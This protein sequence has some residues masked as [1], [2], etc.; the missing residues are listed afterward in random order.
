MQYLED[1]TSKF[2]RENIVYVFSN[3]DCCEEHQRERPSLYDYN[4]GYMPDYPNPNID[5]KLDALSKI[6]KNNCNC[7]CR[8]VSRYICRIDNDEIIL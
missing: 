1:D 5:W 6:G 4:S 3:C 2:E 7:P 8:F